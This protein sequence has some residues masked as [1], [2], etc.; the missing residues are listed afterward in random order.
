MTPARSRSQAIYVDSSALVKLAVQ[1]PESLALARYV[2]GRELVASA[3]SRTEVLRSLAPLGAEAV[4]RGH[5]VLASVELLRISDRVLDAAGA[6][7]PQTLRT[8]D[9]IHLASALQ[10]GGGIRVLTYDM[11]LAE[12]ARDHGLDVIAPH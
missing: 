5:A 4:R 10:L 9:A 12:A 6:L 2:R 3:L 11:R 1:E 8:L 7:A